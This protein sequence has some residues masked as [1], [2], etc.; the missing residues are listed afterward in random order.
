[1]TENTDTGIK[2]IGLTGPS[3]SGKGEVAKIFKDN[4]YEIIDADILAREVINDTVV[5][6]EL[7][8]NFG[9]DIFEDGVLDRKKLAK[10]A[11]SSRENELLLNRITH[12]RI[13]ERAREMIE[14]YIFT[15]SD[16]ILFDAPLLF[17][18]DADMFCTDTVS[19]I[20]GFDKRLER[21]M[22]RDGISREEALMR[23]KVQQDDSYYTD[24]SE[25]VIYNDGSLDDL[26]DKTMKIIKEV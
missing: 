23:M 12:G 21:I 11:F 2:V 24:R 26:Y 10:R 3:G 20:A 19:V 13:L 8:K 5:I 25:Y 14:S 15:G 18:S 6:D 4:G 22:K 16:K 17:E 7:R 9:D 1:M